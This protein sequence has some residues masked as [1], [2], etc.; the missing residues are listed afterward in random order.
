MGLSRYEKETVINFNDEEKIA[1][2]STSQDAMKR[3]IR[4]LAEEHP[5]EVEIT[6]EDKYTLI[7]KIPKK[8]VR[9]SPPRF[10]SEEQRIAAAER[11]KKYR[12]QK[13]K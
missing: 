12:E 7:A 10:V 4:R 11:L 1:Y 13:N 5:N 2:L 9:V 8:Y 3:R 6:S